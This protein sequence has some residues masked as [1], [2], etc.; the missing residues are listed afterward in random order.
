MKLW[1]EYGNIHF[2]S[3]K[4][5]QNDMQIAPELLFCYHQG[6]RK[7]Q[8]TDNACSVELT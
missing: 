5:K 6:W 4:L 3:G 7:T 1:L 8:L 2:E